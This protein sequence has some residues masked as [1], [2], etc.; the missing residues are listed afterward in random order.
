MT[1]EK[2]NLLFHR[3]M[4]DKKSQKSQ[5]QTAQSQGVEFTPY[6]Y[7]TRFDPLLLN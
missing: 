3:S 6:L 4:E 5:F 7:F 1:E 2:S